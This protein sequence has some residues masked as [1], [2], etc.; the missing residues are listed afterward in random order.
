MEVY[1][2]SPRMHQFGKAVLFVFSCLYSWVKRFFLLLIGDIIEIS[3]YTG[4]WMTKHEE[5]RFMRQKH[6]GFVVDGIR[7][8]SL[9]KSFTHCFLS[10][11]T[12]SGKSSCY[13][14]PQ[15]LSLEHSAVV[16]DCSGQLYAHT[17]GYLK[18]QG[19]VVKQLNLSKPM[20]SERYNP[21]LR[22]TSNSQ[23]KKLATLLIELAF[24]EE[25][26]KHSFWGMSAGDLLSL[27][28]QT[29][30][31]QQDRTLRTL[32]TVYRV[33][34]TMSVDPSSQG[35]QWMLR[36]AEESV[37]QEFKGIMAGSS[38]M[39]S[40][41]LATCRATLGKFGDEELAFLTA[42]D[43][44]GDLYTLLR[45]QK[46]VLYITLQESDIAYLR[47]LTSQI[48]TD[49]FTMCMRMPTEDDGAIL[50]LLDEFGHCK[51]DHCSTYL[52]TLRKRRVAC[53]ISVQSRSM[54]LQHY[55]Q[56]EANAI[57]YGGC[58]THIL[59]TGQKERKEIEDVS[60]LLGKR[61][62]NFRGQKIS[63]PLL[64][65]DEIMS[66]KGKAIVL[67]GGTRPALVPLRPYYTD[68]TLVRR[69]SIPAV[70]TRQW[71]NIRGEDISPR[72]ILAS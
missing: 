1:F 21:L 19:F 54:L 61:L 35:V 43:T 20:Q 31:Q 15:L 30:Q 60:A 52:T 7:K 67:H 10:G 59:I 4:R 69:A 58:G 64:T 49:I 32:Q 14:I 62:V 9:E 56:A 38:N 22:A 47:P 33:I 63:R 72:S 39:V 50:M 41:I 12:G 27:V 5:F 17:S 26:D 70:Q 66:T 6:S 3:P 2:L 37:Y 13:Y 53:M 57:V 11:V 55:T 29:A 68:P 18:Q 71:R 44:L 16:L 45:K 36:H 34:H 48:I 24:T 65:P 51:I 42:D 46:T 28:L 8:M 25:K 23:I 40:S